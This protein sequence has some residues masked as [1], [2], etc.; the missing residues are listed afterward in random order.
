[1]HTPAK[2]AY[3]MPTGND[4][5]ATERQNIHKTIVTALKIAGKSFVKPSALFAS[6]FD[7]VPKITAN[8]NIK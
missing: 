1:M 6:E 5:I 4:R 7:A 3:V 8:T 2:D